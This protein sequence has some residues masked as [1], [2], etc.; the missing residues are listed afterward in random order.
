VQT[1]GETV[2]R[3]VCCTEMEKE[4]AMSTT[5]AKATQNNGWKEKRV[6]RNGLSTAG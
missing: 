5:E 6:P 3:R 4:E 2:F 1:G